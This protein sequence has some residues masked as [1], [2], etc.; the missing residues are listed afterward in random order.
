[1]MEHDYNDHYFDGPSRDEQPSTYIDGS[2]GVET[3]YDNFFPWLRDHS[4]W[5]SATIVPWLEPQ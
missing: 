2:R 3:T 5:S 4:S 1:M